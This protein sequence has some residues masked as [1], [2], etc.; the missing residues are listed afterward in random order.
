MVVLV[1]LVNKL[2]GALCWFMYTGAMHQVLN[3]N[4]DCR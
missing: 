1:V 4:Y 3:R 2:I